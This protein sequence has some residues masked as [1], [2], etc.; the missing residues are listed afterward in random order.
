MANWYCKI[1]G[2]IEGPFTSA[3]LKA[4]AFVGEIVPTTP[5]KR[6][7]VDKWVEAH[8][9]SGLEFMDTSVVPE[10]QAAEAA[11]DAPVAET[12]PPESN[13]APPTRLCP[14]CS[15]TIMAT[16]IKC[17]HCGEFFDQPPQTARAAD[18]S[19]RLVSGTHHDA[20]PNLRLIASHQRD[21]IWTVLAGIILEIPIIMA[22]SIAPVIGVPLAFMYM[23]FRI[24]V[25]MRLGLVAFEEKGFGV[26]LALITI[27]PCCVGLI[28]LLIINGKATS[29]L[30]SHN[31]KVG[32]LG[33]D[34]RSI[35]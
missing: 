28:P 27:I 7:G 4:K 23:A 24:V 18:V 8:R 9:V 30:T 19:G 21:L 5:V 13:T 16:A 1:D 3:Q 22:C 35:P 32:L 17:K 25:A 12:V 10:L 29:V 26:L 2:T 31:I 14:F 11:I 15:E 6:D 20:W 34:P 33:V